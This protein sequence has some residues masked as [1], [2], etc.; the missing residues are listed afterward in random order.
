[1]GKYHIGMY[2]GKFLPF[3]LGHRYCIEFAAKECDIL[4]VILFYGGKDEEEILKNHPESW[5]A[6][7]SRKIMLEKLV[8][9]INKEALLKCGN[10]EGTV[11]KIIPKYIDISQLRLPD[12]SEDWDA[13]TPL[14]REI[15]GDR[16]DAVYS[17][18]ESYGEYFLRAYP[19][20]LHR[21]IDVPRIHY[22]I[23]GTDIRGFE[24]EEERTRWMIK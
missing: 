6:A 2:G 3:H 20:A 4:Y 15:C 23:S 16:I 11:P 18:E 7:G 14:V 1:M 22:P 13:E 5:L 19:E 24:S 12:G 9:G 10:N 8:N 17:S 21:L